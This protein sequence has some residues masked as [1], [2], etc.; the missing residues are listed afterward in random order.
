MPLDPTQA[1]GAARSPITSS[2]RPTDVIL[3]HLGLGAGVDRATDPR[4]LEYTYEENLKVLPTFAVVQG[5]QAIPDPNSFPGV[6]ID[7]TRMLHAEHE[8]VLH[9]P[10]EPSGTAVSTARVTD[11]WDKGK[12]ALM[13]VEVSSVD[14]SGAPLFTNR[15]TALFRGEG[16]FGAAQGPASPSDA[17]ERPADAVVETR[18]QPHQALIYRLSGDPNPLHIDPKVAAAAGFERP[19]LHGLCSYGMA[20]KAVVDELL[21]GDVSR[22]TG[23][24]ARFAGV[25]MPG[26]TLSTAMWK[27]G[28]KILLATQNTDQGRGA[29][30][31]ATIEVS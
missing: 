24:R 16:G 29:L 20:C 30:S 27:E 17:P 14:S 11:I 6:D 4:E 22:V 28:N 7:L 12:N 5:L 18:T 21:D 25:V 13:V 9:Q 19:I 23:Y 1:I 15:L 31:H 2:W 8:I 26:D 10:I 3:Y